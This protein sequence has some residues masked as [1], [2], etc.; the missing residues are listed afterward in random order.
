MGDDA[1]TK[2]SSVMAMQ[3]T[4]TAFV[5]VSVALIGVTSGFFENWEGPR[6]IREPPHLLRFSNDSGAFLECAATGH[7]SP[8]VSWY[9]MNDNS[10]VTDV[11]G[12]LRT[13]VN[14]SLEL[15]PFSASSFRPDVHST[16]YRCVAQN[17]VGAVAGRDVKVRGDGKFHML[18]SGDLLVLDAGPGDV[19][20]EFH[21]RFVNRLTGETFMSTRPGKI[22]FKS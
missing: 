19:L 16:T 10:K 20:S 3:T 22:G 18:P 8:T 13:H 21:C 5:F 12:V 17:S 11:P 9:R 4:S 15:L 2:P 1:I 7:P 6:L 14:G